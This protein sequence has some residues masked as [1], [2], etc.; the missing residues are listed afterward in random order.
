MEHPTCLIQTR[1]P[2]GTSA[3]SGESP[4]ADNCP[5]HMGLGGSRPLSLT[6]TRSC[7]TLA[8]DDLG[9]RIPASPSWTTRREGRPCYHS[10]SQPYPSGP[11]VARIRK[12]RALPTAPSTYHIFFTLSHFHPKRPPHAH[13]LRVQQT[14]KPPLFLSQPFH[15]PSPSV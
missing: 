7:F 12:S 6:Q 10:L 11:V 9:I 3:T 1:L 13:R 14:C 8:S 4:N 15:L 5:S 2:S